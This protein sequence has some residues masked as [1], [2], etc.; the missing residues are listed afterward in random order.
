MSESA[1]PQ[2]D[3]STEAMECATSISSDGSTSTTGLPTTWQ[4]PRSAKHGGGRPRGGYGAGFP[5][6]TSVLGML[7]KGDA[8][9]GWAAKLAREGKDWEQERDKAAEL[10]T[11]IHGYVLD[12][13]LCGAPESAIFDAAEGEWGHAAVHAIAEYLRW[14]RQYRP[15]VESV[16]V[17]LLS[18]VYRFGGCLDLPCVID[19]VLTYVDIKTSPRAYGTYAM[20]A[21]AY[22]VLWRENFGRGFDRFMVLCLPKTGRG[23]YTLYDWRDLG[24]A[25]ETFF[26]ARQLYE[27]TPHV[28]RLVK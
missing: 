6:V 12:E 21:A 19:G 5:G 23:K 9:L 16:E 8:L 15:V 17:P 28:D 2:L 24:P 7:S 25:R 13:L 22:D 1:D 11:A 3:F 10:G 26:L 20:Q 14:E 4:P 18:S 27:L